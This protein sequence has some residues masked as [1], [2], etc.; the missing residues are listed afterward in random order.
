MDFEHVPVDRQGEFA[1]ITMNRPQRRNA[2]SLD[3]L[4][5]LP[6]LREGG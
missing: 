6:G 3:H 4:R 1:T 2:L 5:E